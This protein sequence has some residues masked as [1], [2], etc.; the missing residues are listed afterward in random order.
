MTVFG[1]GTEKNKES[2]E[3]CCCSNVTIY[4]P[5]LHRVDG[6]DTH[7]KGRSKL[8]AKP[9]CIQG[10]ICTRSAC[11]QNNP[12]LWLG[13]VV[14]R[15]KPHCVLM[16]QRNILS[17]PWS[18]DTFWATRLPLTVSN[19]EDMKPEVGIA[20]I[21]GVVVGALAMYLGLS[22]FSSEPE[23]AVASAPDKPASKP[24][25][26]QSPSRESLRTLLAAGEPD[27]AEDATCRETLQKLRVALNQEQDNQQIIGILEEL[28]QKSGADTRDGNPVTTWPEGTEPRYQPEGFTQAVDALKKAC[29]DQ[30]PPQTRSNCKEFPCVI[31]LV[32]REDKGEWKGLESCAKYKELFPG[33]TSTHGTGFKDLENTPLHAMHVMPIPTGDGVRDYM[34]EYEGNLHKRRRT[35]HRDFNNDEQKRLFQEACD[36]DHNARACHKMGN[37]LRNSDPEASRNYMSQGCEQ[38]SG[39]AC[40]DL[41]WRMCH[42]EKQCDDA[43]LRAAQRASELNPEDGRGAWDTLGY[44]LCQRGD[45]NGALQAYQRSCAAGYKPNCNKTCP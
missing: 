38:G 13:R 18:F 43:S 5:A 23:R 39:G 26:E 36:Q 32:A 35:R 8:W 28:V 9:V 31:E 30:F 41:A 29:P 19:E 1:N 24:C 15:D 27:P 34:K 7:F 14:C 25:V 20:A 33:G 42:D 45:V 2:R 40:N 37:A 22:V 4:K 11:A 10:F 3:E 44:I 21:V 17:T 6:S 16:L 12:G